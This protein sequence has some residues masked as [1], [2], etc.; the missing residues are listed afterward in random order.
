MEIKTARLRPRRLPRSMVVAP[1][2]RED[3]VTSAPRPRTALLIN[4]FYAKAPHASF[5]KHALTPTLGLTSIA[6]ATPPGWAVRYWDE[7]LLQVPPPQHP[8]PAP[9]HPVPH[10]FDAASAASGADM[11]P[12]VRIITSADGGWTA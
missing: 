11:P 1:V 4:P 9:Q 8:I 3:I 2:L 6:A 5:G 12:V 10:P 7:N